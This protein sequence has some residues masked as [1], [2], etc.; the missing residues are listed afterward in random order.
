[1][2]DLEEGF[3]RLER[4]P[5]VARSWY[6]RQVRGSVGPGVR[7][8]YRFLRDYD[9]N[10]IG[11]TTVT[12]DLRFGLRSLRRNPTVAVVA[13][14]TLAIAIG[15]NTAVFSLVN[16]V[17]FADVPMRDSESV[18]VVWAVNPALRV[19]QGR[20]SDGDLVELIEGVNAFE[21]LSAMTGER[22]VLTGGDEPVRV[23]GFRVTANLTDAWRLPPAL[24]RGFVEGEEEGAAIT[25]TLR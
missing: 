18:A 24:G 5:R 6:W 9:P 1:M 17:I 14:L 16:D 23:R 11:L 3:R 22:W 25:S 4:D 13:T 19:E 10:A 15:A 8:H 12:Q 7:L 20:V 21:Q 2:G